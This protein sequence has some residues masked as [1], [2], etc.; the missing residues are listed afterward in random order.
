MGPLKGNLYIQCE[1]EKE[2]IDRLLDLK[3]NQNRAALVEQ[4]IQVRKDACDPGWPRHKHP[5]TLSIPSMC[6]LHA[7]RPVK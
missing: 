7:S 2:E 3:L 4:L 1:E 6:I 5:A